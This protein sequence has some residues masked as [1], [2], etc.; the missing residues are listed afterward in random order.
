MYTG[1][2]ADDAI[3]SEGRLT[4]AN[5]DSYIGSFLHDACT[6]TYTS[7]P[8]GDGVYSYVS[9]HTY[10]GAFEDGLF[11]GEGRF[12][13][14]NGDEYIGE[15]NHSKMN[16]LGKLIYVCGDVYEGEYCEGKRHGVGTMKVHTSLY[17]FE[18][19]IVKR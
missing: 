7:T 8:H 9:G 19:F 18:F 4:F 11:S 14:E 10:T 5:G 16:G 3:I 6:Q 13:F 2:F 12:I 1:N 17:I 15:F